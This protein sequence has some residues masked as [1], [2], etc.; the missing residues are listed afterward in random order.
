[1]KIKKLSGA[2]TTSLEAMGVDVSADVL[3]P[4][5]KG[6]GL[7]SHCE[8]CYHQRFMTT[9]DGAIKVC[10]NPVVKHGLQNCFYQN[11]EESCHEAKAVES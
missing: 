7:Y 5:G 4:Y 10:G 9:R 6:P 8:F 1:M 11:K 3:I 2:Q